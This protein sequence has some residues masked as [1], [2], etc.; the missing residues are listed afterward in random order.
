MT[1]AIILNLIFATAIAITIVGLLA[2]AIA[3]QF[4]DDGPLQV[5]DAAHRTPPDTPSRAGGRSMAA[6]PSLT[7]PSGRRRGPRHS[8]TA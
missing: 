7:A 2:W 6:R 1:A 4:R 8:L 3:T 5:P